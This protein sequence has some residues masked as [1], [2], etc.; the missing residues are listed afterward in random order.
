MRLLI[1]RLPHPGYDPGNTYLARCWHCSP[2]NKGRYIDR[3]SLSSGLAQKPLV[4]TNEPGLSWQIE[5]N[6]K[7]DLSCLLLTNVFARIGAGEDWS[8]ET[9]KGEGNCTAGCHQGTFDPWLWSVWHRDMVNHGHCNNG[10]CEGRLMGS[11]HL[12]V[13]L[14]YWDWGRFLL[15]FM[16][17][18]VTQVH[19][20]GFSYGGAGQRHELDATAIN[21]WLLQ[22]LGYSYLIL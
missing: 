19:M 13:I 20:L 10:H 2:E 22:S 5:H 14:K 18:W 3:S 11:M 6:N 8:W 7:L 21:Y 15:P 17:G 9:E 16:L 12:K 1:L 4:I